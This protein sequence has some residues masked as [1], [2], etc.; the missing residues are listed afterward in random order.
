MVLAH[1]H[2]GGVAA[3]DHL[4]GA[5]LALKRALQHL[6]RQGDGA[7]HAR[8]HVLQRPGHGVLR[9]CVVL[10]LVGASRA[11]LHELH[12]LVQRIHDG[13]GRVGLL[14][15]GI[16]D[17]VGDRI[18][19]LHGAQLLALRLVVW[20]GLLLRG[21]LGNGVLH[22]IQGVF[23]VVAHLHGGAFAAVDHLAR[24]AL[25]LKRAFQ[26]LHRQGDGVFLARG[27]GLQLPGHHAVLI[28]AAVAGRL[29]AHMLVQGILDDD[30]RLF[31]LVV[32]V[33][34]RV[35]D[36]GAHL[37]GAGLLALRLVVGRGLLLHRLLGHGV[38]HR[39][40]RIRVMV[41][42]LHGRAV[43]AV[44]HLAFAV[45]TFQ[46]ALQHLHRQG[47][48]TLFARGN[49]RDG[50]LHDAAVV[51]A[52][53][54]GL[55]E[56]NMGVQ[57]VLDGDG[58]GFVQVVG[59]ED[60]VGDLVAH[61][62]GAQFLALRLV[63]GRGLALDGRHGVLHGVQLEL[64]VVAHLH[65]G[66]LAAVDHLARAFRH[67][68]AGQHLHR[69]GD[70][71]LAACRNR[72]KCPGHDAAV[73]RTV[74]RA[75][76]IRAH[77]LHVLV[78][79]VLDDDLRILLLVVLEADRIGDLIAHLHRIQQ[80]LAFS[81][82]RRRGHG[83]PLLRRFRHGIGDLFQGKFVVV[84]HLHGGGVAAVDDLAQAALALQRAFQHLHLQGDCAF[85]ALGNVLQRPADHAFVVPA[86]VAGRHELHVLI[87]RIRDDD[88]RRLG[89][90]VPVADLVGDLRAHLHRAKLAGAL[91]GHGLLLVG[92]LRHGVL[93]GIQFNG[94]L[95]VDRDRRS[96]AA[97]DHLARAIVH[98]CQRGVQHLHCQPDGPL[99][100]RLNAFDRPFYRVAFQ[101][102]CRIGIDIGHVRIQRILDDDIR[103]IRRIVHIVDL[104]GD[105]VAHLHGA[106]IVQALIGRD[107]LLAGQ[108]RID[109]L[110]Q[111]VLVVVAH[112]HRGGVAAVDHHARAIR[113]LRALQHLHLQGD[114]ALRIRGHARDGPLHGAVLVLAFIAGLHELNMGVQ[115]VLDDHVRGCVLI[116]LVADLVGDLVVHLHRAQHAR[117]VRTGGRL[118]H[119]L[120]L[121]GRLR[122]GVLHRVQLK[123]MVVAHL[124]GGGVAA[125]DHLA[126]AIVHGCQ[127]GVQHLHC[128]RNGALLARGHGLDGPLHGAALVL[129]AVVRGD[130]LHMAVQLVLDDHVRGLGLVVLIGDRIGDRV[131]RLHGAQS[132]RALVRRGFLLLR[133]FGHR[134]FHFVQGILVVLAHLHGGILAAV[135][136]LARAALALKRAFQH[137]HDQGDSVFPARGNMIQRPGDSMRIL[138][139][140]TP[141]KSI[142]Y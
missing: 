104:I 41:A 39:L 60:L 94:R 54:A 42:H 78:Q 113:H 119:Y 6:H 120:L 83:L 142:G 51:H 84:A 141:V 26:H 63:V 52:A 49:V 98:G 21:R 64:H 29:E 24:A 117:A 71:A 73:G 27:H 11:G 122:N 105:L 132:L 35:G 118:R 135:D 30:V 12:V 129:A 85:L 134:I 15:V 121:V 93:H 76:T 23:L 36:Y 86:A 62:H 40:Q 97:V 111:R 47:D 77:V 112:L 69:H 74:V 50:P 22:L 110:L 88:V 16:A 109:D 56:L 131:A 18:A 46:R 127:R 133:R 70:F 87:Q 28:L 61:L 4:A 44:D 103:G 2:G 115:L 5:V 125:V 81:S 137:L 19:H 48:G 9:V 82:V 130:E 31:G 91:I 38:L 75:V 32:L 100:A 55:H 99:V 65:G 13:D 89:L 106:Q 140:D 80:A 124:H 123:L 14:I 108:H 1:L 95:V 20:R 53:V 59:I 17:R 96:I 10:I 128:Q 126:R 43:A 25:A 37:H 116:V 139:I 72:I 3:V 107:L 66:V 101:E 8:L 57:L 58:R 138:V 68:G 102:S 67:L 114:E 45:V 136:D 79:L 92:R 34:D 33:A 90:V 7:A